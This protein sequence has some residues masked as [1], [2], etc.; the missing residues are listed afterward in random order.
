MDQR[1]EAFLADVLV[2]AG[3]ESDAIRG[4]ARRSRRPPRRLRLTLLIGVA[5]G[6]PYYAIRLVKELR[7]FTRRRNLRHA[8]PRRFSPPWSVEE[9][10]ACFI[11]RDANGQAH[12]R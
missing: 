12:A 2:L 11:V 5:I 8:E 3:E 10:G 9:T 4:E 1:I 6:T 7:H